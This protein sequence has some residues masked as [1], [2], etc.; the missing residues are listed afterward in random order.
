MPGS[1]AADINIVM[2]EMDFIVALL[3][4][5]GCSLLLD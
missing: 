4:G 3:D 2:S 1:I 5:T